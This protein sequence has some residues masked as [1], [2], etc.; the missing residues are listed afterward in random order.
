MFIRSALFL[1]YSTLS[2]AAASFP[3][4]TYS[5]Y[6]RDNFTPNAIAT[7][8][9]GNIYIA[10]N[11]IVDPSTSQTSVLI[12]K[13]NPQATQYLYVRYL[14]GSVHDAANAIAVD[15]A[16]NAY[17]AGWTTSPDFPVTTGGNLGITPA[18]PSER[19]FIAKLDPHGE[20]V[21]SDLI[22]G[23]SSSAAQAVAMN[24]TKQIVVSGMVYDTTFPSTPG[25]YSVANTEGRPYL[26]ELDPTGTKIIFSATGI[27]G[28]ALA[29]DAAGNIYV[30]GT[31]YLLDYPTTP[32]AYQTTFATVSGCFGVSCFSAI[33]GANQ[34]VTKVDPTGSK[35]IYST[36]VSGSNNTTNAGLAVD[37]VGNVYLTGLAGTTYPYTVTPPPLPIVGAP[38]SIP[39][40]P[41]LSKLDVTGT[42]LL[43]SVPVGGA[44]VQLDSHGA[45]YV[46]GGIGSPGAHYVV[47]G[48]I[49][50]LANVPSQCL[51]N[52]VIQNSAYVAQVDASSGSVL[53]SQFI[54]GATL[55][56]SAVALVGSTLWIAGATGDFKVPFTPNALSLPNLEVPS[57]AG[58]YLGGVD[59]SQPQP[60]AGTPQIGCILDSADFS[61][62]GPVARNQLLTIFGSGLMP[63][64]ALG[65]SNLLIGVNAELGADTSPVLYVSPTQINFAVPLVPTAQFFAPL[66]LTVGTL[67]A[68]PRALPLTFANPSVFLNSTQTAALALNADGTVNSATNPAKLASALSVFVNGITSNPQ[69][70]NAPI[71]LY[72]DNGWSVTGSTPISNNLILRVDLRVP[73]Q[74][75]NNFSCPTGSPC[76]V[77]FALYDIFQT[78][79]VPQST[80]INGFAFGSTVFV[81][82]GQ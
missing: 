54:G 48:A 6:L 58:A 80:A 49:P 10:G 62:V 46:G 40:L 42:T 32:G 21:F 37:A 2:L 5:T 9:S 26:L 75:V 81:N 65:F 57:V 30:A 61:A 41:Y 78:S 39:A 12:V 82:R 73:A 34:Y 11:A 14:G 22:G 50:A 43:F 74:L 59:F 35:L 45:V 55:I 76:S 56:P 31:T 3:V 18:A 47:P 15:S 67:N 8:S 44:G 20:L 71:L 79:S 27:G 63:S 70:N 64:P 17:V 24:A 60:S 16:G 1:L 19:S 36:G 52:T 4:L 77:S 25:A 72:S 51:P 53:G 28:S 29:F 38:F 69:V 66:T 33:Q 23:S 7:D 68:S 13:L